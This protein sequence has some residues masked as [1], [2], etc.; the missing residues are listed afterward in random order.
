MTLQSRGNEIKHSQ[1]LDFPTII[2][3]GILLV[4]DSRVGFKFLFL[5]PK[6]GM[7]KFAMPPEPQ[8]TR[9]PRFQAVLSAPL[10][11]DNE[12]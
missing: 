6:Q 2:G 9:P 10:S 4:L 8:V 1:T 5:I 7:W 3:S 11:L 12:I